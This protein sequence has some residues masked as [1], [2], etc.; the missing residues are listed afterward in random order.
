MGGRGALLGACSFVRADA[1]RVA[2]RFPPPPSAEAPR[3]HVPELRLRPPRHPRPLPRVRGGACKESMICP[4]AAAAV[5]RR[6]PREGG[7]G[8]GIE[9]GT[10]VGSVPRLANI[11]QGD[12]SMTSTREERPRR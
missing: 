6:P 8:T 10:L 3:R 7:G 5:T 1:S 2:A 4:A 12:A 11:R 9:V